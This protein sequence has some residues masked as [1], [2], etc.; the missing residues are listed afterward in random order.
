MFSDS[1]FEY[2]AE[3]T[4]ILRQPDRRI[5]TFGDTSFDFILISEL[6]DE[7][8]RI[9]VRNG[10]IDAQRPTILSPEQS[11]KLLVEGLGTDEEGF[12]EW[13]RKN[14]GRFAFLRYGFQVRASRMNEEIVSNSLEGVIQRVMQGGPGES[15]GHAVIRGVDDAWQVCLL[16]FTLDLV[17]KSAPDN[18]S[19]L[20]RNGLL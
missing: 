4:E 3:N 10:R 13:A 2:A 6:M 11:A 20:K 5:R 8:D 9:R 14:T 17:Q 19:D 15:Q 16:K 7:V 1:D 18:F 12:S